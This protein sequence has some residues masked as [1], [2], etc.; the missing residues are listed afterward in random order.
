MA[1]HPQF[2]EDVLRIVEQIPSGH[3]MTYGD[4]AHAIG[5]RAPR[6]VGQ[7]LAHYGKTVAW[8]R[9]VPASGKPPK[10][11]ATLALPHY[12]QEGTPIAPADPPEG[13]RL[14]LALAR[15]PFSHEIYDGAFELHRVQD[16]KEICEK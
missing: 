5:S 8:W 13:Y 11:H 12:K 4:I 3:V 2:V 6:Q 10:G 1:V 15:L 14:R 7:V 9:V 16:L